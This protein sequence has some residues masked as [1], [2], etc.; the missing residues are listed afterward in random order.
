MASLEWSF[1]GDLKDSHYSVQSCVTVPRIVF[2]DSPGTGLQNPENPKNTHVQAKK[3][4][5]FKNE[6]YLDKSDDL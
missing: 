5:F 1:R 4:S 2:L 3:K 6:Y